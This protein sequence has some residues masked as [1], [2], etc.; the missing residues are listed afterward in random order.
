MSKQG[1]PLHMIQILRRSNI[2]LKAYE[3]AD[4]LGVTER[5]VRRYKEFLIELGFE[6]KTTSGCKNSGYELIE[7]GLSD[8]EWI[9]LKDLLK[10]HQYIYKKIE[11]RL[12]ESL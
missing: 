8:E 1:T 2:K 7:V 11:Y 5:Q 9:L 4:I 3:L 12:I 10:D 6:I